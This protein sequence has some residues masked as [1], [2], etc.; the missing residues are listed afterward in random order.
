MQ[1][2][3]RTVP[4]SQMMLWTGRVMSTLVVLFLLFDSVAKLIKIDPVVQ[5]FAA[6]GY[7]DA[8]ARGIGVIVL[9]CA[10]LYA[11]PRTSVLGA[12]LLT[13]LLGGAIS[14]HLR[15][16]DPL[17]SHVLFGVYLGVLAWGGIF[18]RDDRLRAL[19]PMR[20]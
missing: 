1:T 5:S 7:P 15:V 2:Y 12:I 14:S 11:I 13:G 10:L 4:P 16:G 18:L 17:V 8:L 6:L 9:A 19:I 20:A 3:A